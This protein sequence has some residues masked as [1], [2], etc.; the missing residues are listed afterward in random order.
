[1]RLGAGRTALS[2]CAAASGSAEKKRQMM[3]EVNMTKKK[4]VTHQ[5]SPKFSL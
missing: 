2:C 5:V 1:M 4:P 3:E